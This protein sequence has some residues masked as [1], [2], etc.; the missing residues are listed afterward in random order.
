MSDPGQAENGLDHLGSRG[1]GD[2]FR[3]RLLLTLAVLLPV[4]F[5]FLIVGLL[6]GDSQSYLSQQPD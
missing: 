2:R 3:R 1:K 6:S 4:I 5:L